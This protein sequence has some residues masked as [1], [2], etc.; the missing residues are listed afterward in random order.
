M[1]DVKDEKGDAEA[2]LVGGSVGDGAVE[3]R[4]GDEG[5]VCVYGC[6]AGDRAVIGRYRGRGGG[7]PGPAAGGD[8]REVGGGAYGCLR[9]VPGAC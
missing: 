9:D 4:I 7:G 6:G 3:C 5:A 1:E 2:A 8:C